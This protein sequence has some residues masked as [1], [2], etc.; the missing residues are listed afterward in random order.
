VE[1]NVVG[2]TP[3]VSRKAALGIYGARAG[4]EEGFRLLL[5]AGFRS[6]D[7]SV[8]YPENFDSK[9][10]AQTKSDHAQA[11][12]IVGGGSGIV[13]G[14]S[15]G[16]VAG[17]V[18]LA[19]PGVGPFLAAGPLLGALAGAGVGGVAGEVAGA[20]VG[21]GI[22]DTDAK[23]YEGRMKRG[24]ILLSVHSSDA[25]LLT[26]AE[27]ILRQTGAQDVVITHGGAL[28]ESDIA[29]RRDVA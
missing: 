18:A 13:V 16:L 22:S 19:I 7:V 23:N 9:E 21:M 8:L 10:V 1:K 2:Q 15:L 29:T 20:F 3:A 5:S 27:G 28:T 11:G 14:G 17:L 6:E 12:A 25:H 4:A 24:E 26:E